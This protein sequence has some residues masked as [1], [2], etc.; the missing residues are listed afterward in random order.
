MALFN[1]S[2]DNATEADTDFAKVQPADDT[3]FDDN[4]YRLRKSC[5]LPRAGVKQMQ[6]TKKQCFRIKL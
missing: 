3:P 2:W 5:C 6:A 4:I 1:K